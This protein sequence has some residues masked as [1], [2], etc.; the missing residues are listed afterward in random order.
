M[1]EDVGGEGL[2]R[3][4]LDVGV[5]GGCVQSL[6]FVGGKFVDSVQKTGTGRRIVYEVVVIVLVEGIF[7]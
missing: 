1:L 4:D 2:A 3:N 5:F 7:V 6:G